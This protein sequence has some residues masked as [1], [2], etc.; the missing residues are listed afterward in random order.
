MEIP[1]IS[2][3]SDP[4]ESRQDQKLSQSEQ[5]EIDLMTLG[6]A[7]EVINTF[8]IQMGSQNLP[9]EL[10]TASAEELESIKKTKLDQTTI[11]A[12]LAELKRL[13]QAQD[14]NS[15]KL[16]ELAFMT[17]QLKKAQ[18]KIPD[19]NWLVELREKIN[20]EQKDLSQAIKEDYDATM[21][22]IANLPDRY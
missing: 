22:Q 5:K 2:P 15:D 20:L 1:P 19:E 14:D 12:V 13:Y 17:A 3:Q 7:E 18:G 21:D 4:K 10:K 11:N 6:K 9:E 16:H 8:L